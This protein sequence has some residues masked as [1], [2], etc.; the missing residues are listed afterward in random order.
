MRNKTEPFWKEPV[1]T[2]MKKLKL[3]LPYLPMNVSG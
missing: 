1:F 2:K 3:Y